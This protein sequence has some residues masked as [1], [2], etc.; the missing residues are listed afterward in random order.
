MCTCFI[1]YILF[2]RSFVFVLAME[3]SEKTPTEYLR[4]TKR[5]HGLGVCVCVCVYR[6]LCTA[7]SRVPQFFNGHQI[8]CQ[9]F[10]CHKCVV[11]YFL[12]LIILRSVCLIFGK[13]NGFSFHSSVSVCLLQ[14]H[15]RTA[16]RCPECCKQKS[17]HISSSSNGEHFGLFIMKY[18]KH[19]HTR[20]HIYYSHTH[21]QCTQK[22]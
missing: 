13:T 20:V 1:L 21:A 8:I 7:K 14:T 17:G 19:T 3:L 9:P 5:V 22:R 6:T 11:F 10:L 4:Y 2:F 12:F 18:S 16:K 15:V